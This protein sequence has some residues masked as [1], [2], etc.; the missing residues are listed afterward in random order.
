MNNQELERELRKLG[1]V[2]FTG[3]NWQMRTEELQRTIEDELEILRDKVRKCA[4]AEGKI[5]ARL[6]QGS[7]DH[8][9]VTNEKV[10]TTPA[11]T[12]TLKVSQELVIEDKGQLYDFVAKK[13]MTDKLVKPWEFDKTKHKKWCAAMKEVGDELQGA[14]FE[15]KYVLAVTF[16]KE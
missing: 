9:K 6:Q 8:Y 5:R 16:P 13:D 7:E 11:G 3:L 12:A 4:E 10:R 15:E 14:S 1:V 2:E